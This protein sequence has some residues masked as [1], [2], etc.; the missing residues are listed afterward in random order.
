MTTTTNLDITHLADGETNK[1][2]R[3]NE[4]FE[5]VD[6]AMTES[7]AVSVS[8]GNATVTEAQA[9]RAQHIVVSGASSAGRT[10]TLPAMKRQLSIESAAGNAEDIDFVR[11]TATI[12]LAPGESGWVRLDGTTNGMSAIG[13]LG[14]GG[15]ITGID[16]E[17]NGTPVAT[18]TTL[19]FVGA[20]LNDAGGGVV[21]V[22][23]AATDPLFVSG[24]GFATDAVAQINF[25]DDFDITDEGGGEIT[26]ALAAG[27]GGGVDVEE[28][29]SSVATSVTTLNFDGT[30]FNLTDDGGGQVT[31]ELAGAGGAGG[32]APFVEHDETLTAGISNPTSGLTF[33]VTE[34]R[35]YWE[36]IG[37]RFYALSDQ[38]GFDA[39]FYADTTESGTVAYTWAAG[40]SRVTFSGGTTLHSFR[41]EIDWKP[42]APHFAMQVR[43]DVRGAAASYNGVK[44]GAYKDSNNWIQVI[45]DGT[46][47]WVEKR[48]SGSTTTPI[49]SNMSLAWPT[50][51]F[52][53]GVVVVNDYWSVYYRT[54]E[55]GNWI[56]VGARQ[57]T[58]IDLRDPTVMAT[59]KLFY[60]A[61]SSGNTTWDFGA[62]HAGYF[63]GVGCRDMKMV[64]YKDGTPYTVGGYHYFTATFAAPGVPQSGVGPGIPYSHSGVLRYNFLTKHLEKTAA[65]FVRRSSLNY[66]DTTAKIVFDDDLGKWRVLM[67]TWGNGVGGALG[68]SHQTFSGDILNGVHVLRDLASITI[69]LSVGG[70]PVKGAY[71]Q[72]LIWDAAN[73]VWRLGYTYTTDTTFSGT[74]MYLAQ[75]TS[76]DFSTWTN[77]L[78]N[79]ANTAFEGSC[80]FR[81]DG[82]IYLASASS[83]TNRVYNAETNTYV[84]A[85]GYTRP[86]AAVTIIPHPCLVPV[87][88]QNRTRTFLFTFDGSPDAS[89]GDSSWSS[90]IIM[91]APEVETGFEF[92]ARGVT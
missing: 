66:S 25:T 48:V 35:R 82:T 61:Y 31:I 15:G 64:T 40:V 83:S 69:G 50:A 18:A 16:I 75:D 72:D 8:S 84:A 5:A 71:D 33:A 58:G 52:W 38:L 86:T 88:A 57:V 37:S 87:L 51:P 21:Q 7:L 68:I 9:Q 49:G 11:G 67:G 42:E 73:S 85:L 77:V 92:P 78:A 2:V 20:S 29:G 89:N 63:G 79:S 22:G 13:N 14:T 46:N 80:F 62:F 17:D 60:G 36:M 65:I 81:Y 26:I 12:T 47:A 43:V 74:P 24:E 44:L 10:I 6:A 4:G 27:V 91:E 54:R 1:Y 53:L 19:D 76:S 41:R 28:G 32:G 30:D 56:Y 34:R 55:N 59:Y 70:S 45:W 23:F 3:V 39:K 90:I